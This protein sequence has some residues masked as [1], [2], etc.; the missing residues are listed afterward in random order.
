LAAAT[1][2]KGEAALR[3]AALIEAA[4]ED[5]AAYAAA[6]AVLRLAGLRDLGLQLALELVAEETA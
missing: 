1:G 4:P 3:A 6:G 5:P 2:A